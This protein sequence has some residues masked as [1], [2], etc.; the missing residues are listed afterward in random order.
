MSLEDTRAARIRAVLFDVDGV[1]TD[2]TTLVGPDGAEWMGFSIRDGL[3]LVAAQRAGLVTGFV[4]SRNSAPA[5]QRAAHLGIRHV[6]LGVSDKVAEVRQIAEVEGL[7]LDAV[8]YMGDDLVDLPVL[9]RVGLA[10]APADAAAE[11][12]AAAHLVTS[13]RAGHGAAREFIEAVLVAQG[14][15]ARIVDEYAR[16]R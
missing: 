3:A 5:A 13:A 1:L 14:A 12:R 7:G 15:W 9:Q 6:R 10:A 16:R 4:S 2:G 11:V 8:A